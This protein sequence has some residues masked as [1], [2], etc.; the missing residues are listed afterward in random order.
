MEAMHFLM[1]WTTL[2]IIQ[3]NTNSQEF[4]SHTNNIKS[5][6]KLLIAKVCTTRD[7]L[8]VLNHLMLT[9]TSEANTIMAPFYP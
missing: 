1:G 4:T 3:D 8:H 7:T 2:F 9:T 5:E 6:N